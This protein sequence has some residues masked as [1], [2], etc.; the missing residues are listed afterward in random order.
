[1]P[2]ATPQNTPADG[3]T[4]QDA[5]KVRRFAPEPIETTTK[6][7]KTA[8]RHSPEKQEVPKVR[9]FAPEPIE[10]STKSSRSDASSGKEKPAPRR[11][12]PQPIETS[13][14]SSKD[15]AGEKSGSRVSRFKPELVETVHGG[16]RKPS[17]QTSTT[18]DAP[19]SVEEKATRKFVPVVLSTARRSRR[20]GDGNGISRKEM[21]TEEGHAVHAR[22]LQKH[23]GW[24]TPEPEKED[25]G[26]V[27]PRSHDFP[28]DALRPTAPF[29]GKP[30]PRSAALQEKSRSH[31]F[32]CPDLDTIESSESERESGPSS[33]SMSVSPAQG[34]PITAS[35][36]S[37]NEFYKHATRIRESVDENF[38]QYLLQLEAKKAERRLQ[39]AAL[40]AFPNSDFHEPVQ[41][42]VNDDQDS[43]EDEI[44][45]RP[46]TWEGFDEEEFLVRIRR[47]STAKIPW[48]QLEMQ[49][50]AE[51][52]EQERNANKTTAKKE[53]P[54][55]W[56]NPVSPYEMNQTDN[57]MRSMR[58]RARPPML[59]YD[60]VFARCPSP[61]PARF[62]V[63]Q[64]SDKLRIQMLNQSRQ[65]SEEAPPAEEE[66]LWSAAPI[67]K[68][69]SR[70]S[71]E[72]KGENK[73]KTGKGLWGGFCVGKAEH[74]P[75]TVGLL[76]PPSQTGL[77]T[78]GARPET[79]NPFEQSFAQ[80]N[81]A[82][83]T[84]ALKTPPTPPPDHVN[85]DVSRLDAI[86]AAEADFEETFEREYPDSFITQVYNYLSLGY[87]SLARAFDEELSKI[88]RIPIAELRQDD[89]KAKQNPRGYIRLDPDFEGGGGEGT[90]GDAC[91]RW[92]ALK[93]YVKE[94][95]RQEKNMVRVDV[96][97]GNWATTNRRGS[98]AI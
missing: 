91:M 24:K 44:E 58:D 67:V 38:S 65:P 93:L 95:A 5:P 83:G 68:D 70:S 12:A 13:H 84:N 69:H 16:N 72:S 34:S 61:E 87:P 18:S 54:S 10:T 74:D 43:L 11:F 47:D 55:P 98:W 2:S 29:D 62:D 23:A 88:S 71:A 3:T 90:Q 97:G 79:A 60:L 52:M 27:S 80:R 36:S 49:R 30:P 4:K 59:G 63:T 66:G 17:R 42:Y 9:R 15:K 32:R 28:S 73:S 31:S 92:R 53:A 40:A 77:M 81:A 6:S 56:W 50:H 22:E 46:V 96:P 21:K 76:P 45:D 37:F 14:K 8:R 41:H 20:A 39:E 64:G 19:S 33:R 78:P 1:M 57:E 86:L 26:N 94:W 82:S 85:P 51:R 75:P 25:N 35:D 7:S 48:E 89:I